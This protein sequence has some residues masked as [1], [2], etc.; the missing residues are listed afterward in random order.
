MLIH[1]E[2]TGDFNYLLYTFLS[3]LYFLYL[4][5]L[6]LLNKCIIFIIRRKVAILRPPSSL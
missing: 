1:G 4:Q 6:N 3:T 2:I 5:L